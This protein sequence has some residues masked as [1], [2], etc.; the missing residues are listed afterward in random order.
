MN[1]AR[2]EEMNRIGLQARA[3][4]GVVNYM[5]HG[6]KVHGYQDGGELYGAPGST[7]ESADIAVALVDKFGLNGTDRIFW[8]LDILAQTFIKLGTVDQLM[9]LS[10]EEIEKITGVDLKT[11]KAFDTV[12]P[13]GHPDE[14]DDLYGREGPDFRAGGGLVAYRQEGGTIDPFIQQQNQARLAHDSQEEGRA[15]ASRY[16]AGLVHIGSKDFT[17]ASDALAYRERPFVES[18]NPL[19]EGEEDENLTAQILQALRTANPHLT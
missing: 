1:R 15:R 5:K 6:G 14:P 17:G 2:L 11:G 9:K 18:D 8:L 7:Q 13:E 4:G 3:A 19:V 16:G 10:L 12:M